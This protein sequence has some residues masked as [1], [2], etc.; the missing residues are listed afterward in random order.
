MDRRGRPSYRVKSMIADSNHVKNPTASQYIE[1]AFQGSRQFHL[2]L[3]NLEKDSLHKA[4]IYSGYTE[5][6]YLCMAWEDYCH[7][8]TEF[9]FQ[10]GNILNHYYQYTR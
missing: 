9:L 7:N 10:W 4:F 1:Q 2:W 8:R 5:S 3:L 6:S